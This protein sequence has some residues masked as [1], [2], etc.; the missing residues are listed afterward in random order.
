MADE[1]RIRT[2]RLDDW[3]AHAARRALR[4]EGPS[5]A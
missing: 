5:P 1:V 2:R 3:L 4:R